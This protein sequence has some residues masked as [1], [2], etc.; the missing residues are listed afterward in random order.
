[1]ASSPGKDIDLGVVASEVNEDEAFQIIR[2]VRSDLELPKSSEA[3]IN[4]RGIV[5]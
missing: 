2:S 3:A 5:L 1:M 4:N